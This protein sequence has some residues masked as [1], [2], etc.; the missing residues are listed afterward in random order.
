MRISDCR[1]FSLLKT[2]TKQRHSK[3]WMSLIYWSILQLLWKS[4]VYYKKRVLIPEKVSFSLEFEEF[5][6]NLEKS[7]RV[8]FLFTSPRFSPLIQTG[9]DDWS[10][11][12]RNWRRWRRKSNVSTSTPRWQCPFSTIRSSWARWALR[13]LNYRGRKSHKSTQSSISCIES[14]LQCHVYKKDERTKS[15]D[16][17]SFSR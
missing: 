5:L 13:Y 17:E 4:T 6:E 9:G 11:G 16:G 15:S 3:R 1:A 8:I 14:V 7:R 10:N 2:W 12:R